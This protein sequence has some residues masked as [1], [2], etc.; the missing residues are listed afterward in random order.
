MTSEQE[1]RIF[2]EFGRIEEMIYQVFK[3]FPVLN[4]NKSEFYTNMPEPF[5][6]GFNSREL[7]M[8]TREPKTDIDRDRGAQI[9]NREH[10]ND[11]VL[12]EDVGTGET[13]EEREARGY[14]Y[15]KRPD[16]ALAGRDPRIQTDSERR[17]TIEK[18][19]AALEK[20]GYPDASIRIAIKAIQ[21]EAQR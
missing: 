9:F 6:P 8:L 17:Y 12:S 19:Q 7:E 3:T 11:P 15:T 14:I 21:A 4:E 5:E 16:H 2:K 10:V 13:K 18:I 20:A 1:F